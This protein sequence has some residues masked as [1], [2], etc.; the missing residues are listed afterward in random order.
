[1]SGPDFPF[2]WCSETAWLNHRDGVPLPF[3]AV[4]IVPTYNNGRTLASVLE[5]IDNLGL[6]VIVVNDGSTDKTIHIL[7]GWQSVGLKSPASKIVVEHPRNLGKAAA[8]QKGF[9]I[10]KEAGH[11]HAVTIDS[12]GQLDPEQIPDLLALAQR[13]PGALVLGVRDAGR[14]DYPVKSR[15]GRELSNFLIRL[16]CWQRIMDSQCGL[17]VYPLA[18]VGSLRCRARRY[19]YETEIITRAIWAGWEIREMPARCRYFPRGERMSHFRPWLDTARSVG[20]H[21][22]LL[23]TSPTLLSWPRFVRLWR[24][25]RRNGRSDRHLALALACGVFIGNQPVYGLQTVLSLCAAR[26]FGLSSVAVVLGSFISTP[27]LSIPLIA[28]AVA[29]GHLLLHGS[30]PSGADFDAIH[31]GLSAVAGSTALDWVVGAPIV[32]GFLSACT[33]S[34]VIGFA[35][36]SSSRTH[37][38]ASGDQTGTD[39]ISISPKR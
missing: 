21:A 29:A 24:V 31:R 36:L 15:W 17:R 13:H 20:M 38:V 28:A 26:L 25:V 2:D 5:R 8:L 12:D 32:G 16:E 30:M 33:F 37:R 1:M 35:K 22:R 7:A 27:P 18:M 23:L 4:V 10:A 3:S 6:P 19:G 9:S 34:S 39:E 14:P 11:T